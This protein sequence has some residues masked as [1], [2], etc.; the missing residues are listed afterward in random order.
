MPGLSIEPGL[1]DGSFLSQISGLSIVPGLPDTGHP[2]VDGSFILSN[3]A[4]GELALGDSD[5][6]E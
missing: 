1:S 5:R 2:P 4:L 3:V 6:N